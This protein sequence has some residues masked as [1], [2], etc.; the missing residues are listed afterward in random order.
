MGGTRPQW[1]IISWYG[2]FL[3]LSIDITEKCRTE[4]GWI[5]ADPSYP[6]FQTY[7]LAWLMYF[8]INDEKYICKVWRLPLYAISMWKIK[9]LRPEEGEALKSVLPSLA[10]HCEKRE[11]IQMVW[12]LDMGKG[13]KSPNAGASQALA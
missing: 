11:F 13:K 12:M 5:D 3:Q 1:K 9:H 2:L 10:Y 4:L 7:S 6:R 8:V